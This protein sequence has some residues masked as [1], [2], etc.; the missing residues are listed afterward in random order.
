M[1]DRLSEDT[2]ATLLMCA[3]LG[4][5]QGLTPLNQS[6]YIRVAAWLAGRNLRPAN[7]LDDACQHEAAGGT[8]LEYDRLHMLLGRGVQLGFC[9]EEWQRQSIWIS[10][11]SDSDYPLR[12]RDAVKAK[13]PPLLFGVGHR[14]LL[15]LG[16]FALAGADRLTLEADRVG[17]Q[18]A[19]LAAL[20]GKCAIAGGRGRGAPPVIVAAIEAGGGAI[21]VTQDNLI[22]RSL[23][24]QLS[25]AFKSKRLA[26][27]ATQGPNAPADAFVDSDV[28]RVVVGLSDAALFID[29]GPKGTDRFSSAEAMRIMH[30]RRQIFVWPGKRPSELATSLTQAGALN[31]SD[32]SMW[33]HLGPDRDQPAD[34]APPDVQKPTTETAEAEPALAEPADSPP[35]SSEAPDEAT[36]ART[37]YEAVLPLLKGACARPATDKEISADLGLAIGQLRRWLKHGSDQG[38]LHKQ[39]DGKWAVR[40]GFDLFND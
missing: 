11:R 24:K 2:N 19:A 15:N 17:R 5:E 3:W 12:L 34:T 39:Q 38:D 18:A 13:A 23:D 36:E 7:L 21:W 8:A 32:Q 14:P 20:T 29:G 10:S 4:G 27:I 31:W 16:G 9:V 30:T 1:L 6:E 37:V 26:L 35:E 22:R 25:R 33:T 28:G 40:A